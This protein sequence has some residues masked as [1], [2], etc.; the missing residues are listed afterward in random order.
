MLCP[1]LIEQARRRD[2]RNPAALARRSGS[3]T[4]PTVS[5]AGPAGRLRRW[6]FCWA[7]EEVACRGPHA[8]PSTAVAS[9]SCSAPHAISARPEDHEKLVNTVITRSAPAG[10]PV[11]KKGEGARASGAEDGGS[12]EQIKGGYGEISSERHDKCGQQAGQRH[13]NP[14]PTATAL[15]SLLLRCGGPRN[16]KTTVPLITRAPTNHASNLEG[17]IHFG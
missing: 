9:P 1:L 15:V 13:A 7:R 2:M 17:G 8:A 3:E 6:L 12:T 5:G 14:L 11:G 10:R 4:A 16:L